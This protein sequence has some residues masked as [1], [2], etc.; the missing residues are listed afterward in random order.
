MNPT[1]LDQVP[2]ATAEQWLGEV[3]AQV[4]NE[5]DARSPQTSLSEVLSTAQ[6]LG[7]GQSR[8]GRLQ[9]RIGAA[10]AL[11]LSAAAAALWWLRPAPALT[12]SVSGIANANQGYIEAPGNP[13]S[14]V[15]LRFSEGSLVAMTPGARLRVDA[16]DAKGA[17]LALES[18]QLDA[19]ITHRVHSRW[20]VNAGPFT[21]RITGTA[22]QVAWS[23]SEHRLSLH[24]RQGSL[25]V[26]GPMAPTGVNVQPGQELVADTDDGSL[27]INQVGSV[28]TQAMQ[29]A[30]SAVTQSADDLP[31]AESALKLQPVQLPARA[32]AS[33]TT[34]G[35]AAPVLSWTAAVASGKS[36]AVVHQA[37][38][39][40]VATAL[41]QR[42]LADLN[43][44]ADAAR[45]LARAELAVRSYEALRQRAPGTAVAASAAFQLGR[46]AEQSGDSSR[47]LSFYD[48]YARE[49]PNGTYAPEAFGRKLLVLQR[50]KNHPLAAAAA[51]D[52]LRRFPTGTY[53][54]VA[55]AVTEAPAP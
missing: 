51:R 17:S 47:A 30:P 13:S 9:Q 43:A 19:Q 10:L 29:Q 42:P 44:L 28:S 25:V 35:E 36:A 52:Y 18:G 32:V 34:L 20:R 39:L 3:G 22:F 31:F 26:S 45:Y 14:P 24:L 12:Y 41:A 33:N 55:R 6:L 4:R 46:L 40:G 53:A 21:V 11:A 15:A 50:S 1:D 7:A 49:A 2:A 23:P 38:T 27:R 5:L 48:T 54:A 37:E 8:S 16:L